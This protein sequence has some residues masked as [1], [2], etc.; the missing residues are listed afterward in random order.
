VRHERI[1][2]NERPFKC[3]ECD[4]ASTRRDKLKEHKTRHHGLNASAKS[5]YKPR[6]HKSNKQSNFVGDQNL[7]YAKKSTVQQAQQQVSQSQPAQTSQQQSQ[8]QQVQEQPTTVASGSSG[9]LEFIIPHSHTDGGNSTTTFAQLVAGQGG[10]IDLQ[11]M[12]NAAGLVQLRQFQPGKSNEV[13]LTSIPTTMSSAE[14]QRTLGVKLED[15]QAQGLLSGRAIKLEDLAVTVGQSGAGSS[16]A[17]QGLG[18]GTGRTTMVLTPAQLQQF[19]QAVA[20][21][22]ANPSFERS[23]VPISIAPATVASSG[24]QVTQQ[25][26]GT[27]T[28][29]TGA[30]FSGLSTLLY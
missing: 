4:Y 17:T 3:E 30:E 10:A 2:F 23:S 1:H 21:S 5:P 18:T 25:A 26:A 28:N 9:E 16:S 29:Q 24:A 13:Q 11:Q 27:T 15:L 7:V 20:V 14:L 8:S 19:T 6:P 12:A 22:G